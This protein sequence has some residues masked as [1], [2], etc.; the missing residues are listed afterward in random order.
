MF[1]RWILFKIF[2][3]NLK[4]FPARPWLFTIVVGWKHMNMCLGQPLSQHFQG[5][6]EYVPSLKA[7]NLF[8]HPR[9]PLQSSK[10]FELLVSCAYFVSCVEPSESSPI[11]WLHRE[12][13]GESGVH[14]EASRL[15]P[16]FFKVL[17]ASVLWWP[18]V[19]ADL[20]RLTYGEPAHRIFTVVVIHQIWSLHWCN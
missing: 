15:P 11:Q 20:C 12:L 14:M 5:F 10:M 7:S 2:G 17:V 6:L 3:D 19:V 9:D 1:W 8:Q 4:Y 16:W 13:V 18:R